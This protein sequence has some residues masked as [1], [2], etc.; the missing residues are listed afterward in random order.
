M[1]PTQVSRIEGNSHRFGALVD[2]IL[3]KV[4]EGCPSPD[5]IHSHISEFNDEITS[6]HSD[7]TV[8]A[9]AEAEAQA[10]LTI[11]QA[12]RK[13]KLT[14]PSKV[15]DK[16]LKK[17]SKQEQ[18][19]KVTKGKSERNLS[20]KVVSNVTFRKP[21]LH[22]EE[23]KIIMAAKGIEPSVIKESFVEKEVRMSEK[24]MS[25]DEELEELDK[26]AEEVAPE[27]EIGVTKNRVMEALAKLKDAPTENHI[28]KWKQDLGEDGVH[29][30][31][32]SEKEIYVYRHLSRSQWQKVQEMIS[33]LQTAKTN[34][35]EDELKEKVVT[36]CILWPSLTLEWKYNSRAGVLDA[37]YQAIMLQS[38]FLSPQ[39]VMSLTC[40]L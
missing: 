36:H 20:R 26:K 31:V 15:D 23:T 16:I 14:T 28:K 30:T 22:T 7:R 35:S 37:L 40:E 11:E 24:D 17:E 4:L 6:T 9:Q 8:N 39:Q 1:N 34:V 5:D 13:L 10:R 12:A 18:E 19:I 25:L 27:P 2:P 3:S 38:Y 21:Q 29:V 32:F 33:K